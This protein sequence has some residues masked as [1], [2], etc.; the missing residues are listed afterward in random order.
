[1]GVRGFVFYSRPAAGNQSFPIA[2]FQPTRV[3]M[4]ILHSQFSND[5]SQ[6]YAA[7]C[8]RL[9]R[10]SRNAK[11]ARPAPARKAAR[12]DFGWLTQLF[13]AQRNMTTNG[14]AHR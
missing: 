5:R 13:S 10:H 12:S 4:A 11:T 9:A 8:K 1:M 3:S 6:R 7:E 2:V 14:F